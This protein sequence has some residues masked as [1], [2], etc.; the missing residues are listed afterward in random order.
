MTE[1]G[2]LAV[3]GATVASLVVK[4]ASGGAIFELF[5]ALTKK[6]RVLIGA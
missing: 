5:G 2:L 6:V 3:V 4:W 1:Y